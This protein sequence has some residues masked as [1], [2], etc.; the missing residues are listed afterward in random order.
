MNQ[1]AIQ[2]A[3]VKAQNRVNAFMNKAVP[4]LLK[5][6]RPFVGEQIL[7]VEG[8]A[9]KIKIRNAIRETVEGLNKE[10]KTRWHFDF[11]RYSVSIS[12]DCYEE[13]EGITYYQKQFHYL[14]D[15][16]HDNALKGLYD[17]PQQI[18]TFRTDY[19]VAWVLE[20]KKE[21]AELEGR[22]SRLLSEI[23]DFNRFNN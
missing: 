8:N 11:S 10:E 20:K 4:L 12:A 1:I 9:F 6:F 18:Q 13:A 22:L 23:S 5:A 15:I 3:K 14:L 17:A 19:S 21:A 2:T 7:L 16:G